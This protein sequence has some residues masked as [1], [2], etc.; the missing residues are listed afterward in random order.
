MSALK[1]LNKKSWHT[2]TIKNNEKVWLREQAA[3]REKSRMDEL[4]KQLAE[5]RRQEELENLEEANGV[6]DGAAAQ[7]RK[8]LNWMYEYT[9]EQ[10][11]G[12]STDAGPTTPNDAQA[13]P[14]DA[15]ARTRE[16]VLL[17][18]RAVD[19]A[20]A[21]DLSAARRDAT[22]ALVDAEAKLREDPLI[23]IEMARVR[24]RA[25]AKPG[26]ELRGIEKQRRTMEATARARERA[27]RKQ[28]RASIREQR[29]ERRDLRTRRAV[30]A[31]QDRDAERR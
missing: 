22:S 26:T 3:A 13:P 19:D 5:E 30:A 29:R 12:V 21:E 7:K 31:R 2:S 8:R 9:K 23:A 28:E 18:R 17:G 27:A 6:S 24:A 11:A 20:M 4:Q 15:D 14:P 25:S 1:F 16:D 10:P